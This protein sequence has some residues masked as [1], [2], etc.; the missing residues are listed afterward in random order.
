MFTLRHIIQFNGE[1]RRVFH[2]D[3]LPFASSP[4]LT[5][6]IRNRCIP[7]SCGKRLDD[8]V[9]NNDLGNPISSAIHTFTIFLFWVCS[10]SRH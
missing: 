8:V 9:S 1:Q 5:E 3:G 4:S 2:S 7:H 6:L 10:D